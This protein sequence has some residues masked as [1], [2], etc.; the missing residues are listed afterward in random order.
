MLAV[1]P[2]VETAAQRAGAGLQATER[3]K[4][5]LALVTAHEETG[6]DRE[7]ALDSGVATPGL[8][9]GRASAF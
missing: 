2:S 8:R 5:G 3:L 1:D 9:G 6:L 7:G 4:M